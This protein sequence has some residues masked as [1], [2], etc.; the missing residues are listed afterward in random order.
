MKLHTDREL[1]AMA[2][3]KE[4]SEGNNYSDTEIRANEIQKKCTK[5]GIKGLRLL[6]NHYLDNV[7]N[8]NICTLADCIWLMAIKQEIA[9]IKAKYGTGCPEKINEMK[10]SEK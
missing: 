5:I 6:H 8:M 4:V 9:R 3:Q 10:E 7:N 2:S 1:M